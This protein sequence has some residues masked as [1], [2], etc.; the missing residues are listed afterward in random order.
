MEWR[1][2]EIRKLRRRAKT[3]MPLNNSCT[4]YNKITN[5]CDTSRNLSR[6]K[7]SSHCWVKY[8]RPPLPGSNQLSLSSSMNSS[9]GQIGPQ[10]QR[11]E[12]ER[13]DESEAKKKAREE[14]ATEVDTHRLGTDT[15]SAFPRSFRT[16]GR[17][18]PSP[19]PNGAI[20]RRCGAGLRGRP[21]EGGQTPPGGDDNRRSRPPL[22]PRRPAASARATYSRQSPSVW[23]VGWTGGG[24]V[25]REKK[26]WGGD[27]VQFTIDIVGTKE[28]RN[29]DLK[30]SRA[31]WLKASLLR[32]SCFASYRFGARRPRRRL[33]LCRQHRPTDQ[34]LTGTSPSNREIRG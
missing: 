26:E 32:Y 31:P 20:R 33:C 22:P 24:I 30:I 19:L 1:G 14:T 3:L 6:A 15:F 34:N 18:P 13:N 11:R 4:W 29:V 27:R 25:R 5:S 28:R 9:I 7:L 12:S 23:R 16:R 8:S 17:W 10:K 2:G 21:S